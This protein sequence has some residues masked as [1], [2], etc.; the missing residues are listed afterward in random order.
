METVFVIGLGYELPIVIVDG[1]TGSGDNIITLF[2][3]GCCSL[4]Y[5]RSVR[6]Y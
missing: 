6:T 3:V 2:L 5:D 1:V 4:S